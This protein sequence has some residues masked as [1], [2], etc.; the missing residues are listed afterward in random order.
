[1]IINYQSFLEVFAYKQNCFVTPISLLSSFFSLLSLHNYTSFKTIAFTTYEISWSWLTEHYVSWSEKLPVYCNSVRLE[2]LHTVTRG[3]DG[4]VLP[5]VECWD[6][7]ISSS[8][9]SPLPCPPRRA[10]HIHN[11][12]HYQSVRNEK[13]TFFWVFVSFRLRSRT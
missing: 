8:V 11:D 5:I 10:T 4:K 7:N 6:T 3:N 13:S 2:L 9:L 1:M 12:H